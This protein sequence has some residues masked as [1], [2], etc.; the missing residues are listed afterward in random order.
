MKAL[1]HSPTYI[2][3]MIDG[4]VGCGNGP[5]K[6]GGPPDLRSWDKVMANSKCIEEEKYGN[7]TS[8]T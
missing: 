1:R 5:P 7:V 6:F 8:C 4:N 3:T 2:E